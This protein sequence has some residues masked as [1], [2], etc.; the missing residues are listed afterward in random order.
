MSPVETLFR[1][2]SYY[3][4]RQTKGGYY[5]QRP[6]GPLIP[7]SEAY[8][9]DLGDVIL[10]GRQR[11]FTTIPD[12][13][14]YGSSPTPV[15]ARANI[16]GGRQPQFTS[17][18]S[19]E[20]GAAN[21]GAA[22]LTPDT[23]I[24]TTVNG[25]LMVYLKGEG[26]MTRDKFEDEFGPFV[27]RPIHIELEKLPGDVPKPAGITGGAPA[28]RDQ[29]NKTQTTE[30]RSKGVVEKKMKEEALMKE[31]D[32][33]E[34]ALFGL[35]PIRAKDMAVAGFSLTGIILLGLIIWALFFKE[36]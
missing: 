29:L 28:V 21:G 13:G 34:R 27:R 19:Y 33:M 30:D 11:Q 8:G 14:S 7:I 25:L 26:W 23:P 15:G 36:G 9:R 32:D 2:F 20:L 12:L 18:P 3:G 24:E 6:G 22:Q 35:L 1:E 10:G 16:L 17:I 31:K 5:Q 4:P